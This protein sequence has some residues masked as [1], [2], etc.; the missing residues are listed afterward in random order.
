[1]TKATKAT[2]ATSSTAP[3][4]S[5]DLIGIDSVSI[6]VKSDGI[7]WFLKIR[8]VDLRRAGASTAPLKMKTEI[9]FAT[10]SGA[11]DYLSGLG[12]ARDD[13]LGLA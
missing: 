6:R 10:L 9:A 1:M 13:L 5:D 12:T 4:S 8:H 7:G 11:T 2:K 3:F